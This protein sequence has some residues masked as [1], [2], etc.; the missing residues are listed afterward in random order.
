[1][2]R[3]TNRSHTGADHQWDLMRA[4]FDGDW[5]GVTSWYGRDSTGMNLTRGDSD[6]AG[7][8]YAIRFSDANTGLWHGTG[9]RFAP[10]GERRFPL[11]RHSYNLSNNCWHFPDT[12]GQ[13]SLEMDGSA[14]RAGHEVNFFNGRSR[15]MLIALYQRREDQSMV[16]QS[17]AATPF[18]CKRA[19]IDPVRPKPDSM[20]DVFQ[21]I[22]GWP[23]IE[24]ELRPGQG[25]E[26]ST[27][28]KS[29]AGF[30]A[31][32]FRKYDIN[33]CFLDGLLCSL[34]ECLPEGAF[35]LNFGCLLNANSFVHL[36]IGYDGSHQL[37]SWVERRYQPTID[38]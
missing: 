36:I 32:S 13:S 21:A 7:S 22:T 18:R 23:G 17:I 10:G 37:V 30:D 6:P 34:P 11:F 33:G 15:S 9:L 4:S 29:I 8:I 5:Q 14:G 35:D 19:L 25:S 38:G 16:L 1:M 31:V 24:Q 3:T 12:A 20:H 28:G 2:A 27:Q 26:N